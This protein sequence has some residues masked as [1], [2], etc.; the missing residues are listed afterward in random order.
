MSN[1]EMWCKI[2]VSLLWLTYQVGSVD[3]VGMVGAGQ[4]QWRSLSCLRMGHRWTIISGSLQWGAVSW[5]SDS[6]IT[7]SSHPPS[8]SPSDVSAHIVLTFVHCHHLAI[9]WSRRSHH[10]SISLVTVLLSGIVLDAPVS[11]CVSSA[12]TCSLLSPAKL[13]FLF[14]Y[15]LD[16]ATGYL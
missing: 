15:L 1:I 5:A 13:Q 10:Y 16:P 3:G 8:L 12:Q 6:F 7:I 2:Q 9:T 11:G 14:Q 4:C